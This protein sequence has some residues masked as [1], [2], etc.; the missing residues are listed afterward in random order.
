[1][2]FVKDSFFKDPFSVRKIAL[3]QEY[4]PSG[5]STDGIHRWPG[6][7]KYIVY[8]KL[9]APGFDY[10]NNHLLSQAQDLTGQSLKIDNA[11]F[12][13]ITKD[14]IKGNFHRDLESTYTSILF[15][16]VDVPENSGTEVCDYDPSDPFD[17]KWWKNYKEI[18]NSFIN[19]PQNILKKYRYK[20]VSNK[21]NSSIISMAQIPNKFNRF[22][23]FDSRL[24]HRAQKYFG[25]AVNDSRLTIVTFFD[26]L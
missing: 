2:L 7:R 19:D 10:I 16:S 22:V 23:L 24:L 15:L 17:D 4:K 13:F 3:K 18:E 12:Q 6:Y 20:W 9:A 25:K 1:V 21:L 11:S 26:K 14:F 8:D 5:W